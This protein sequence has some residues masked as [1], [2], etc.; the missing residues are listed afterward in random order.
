M[1]GLIYTEGTGKP[2]LHKMHF[3]WRMTTYT[4][5]RCWCCKREDVKRFEVIVM[6]PSCKKQ[7]CAR[8]CNS[9]AYS[10]LTEAYNKERAGGDILIVRNSD[11]RDAK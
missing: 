9:I 4:W 1:V 5:K 2:C 6:C 3:C 7:I 11:L 8:C 10:G